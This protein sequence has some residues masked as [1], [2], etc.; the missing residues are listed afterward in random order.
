[1]EKMSKIIDC[2]AID[3]VYNKNKQC[4]TMAINIGDLEPM[5]D[6]F[7]HSSKKFGYDDI[8][9]GV[10]SCKVDGCAYN[11]SLE[12]TASGIHMEKTGSH[13]DCTTYR[14]K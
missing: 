6:T 5:C 7:L 9:G 10:G 4:H 8:T 14:S 13:V 3:C 12:C 1:M 2:N 11:K